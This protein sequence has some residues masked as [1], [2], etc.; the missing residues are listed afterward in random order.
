MEFLSDSVIQLDSFITL[1]LGII[2]LFIGIKITARIRFLQ[3]YNIPEPVTGGIFASL[4]ALALY[5]VGGW[6]VEYDLLD[7]KST[8]LNSSHD[9]ISYAVFCLKKKKQTTKMITGDT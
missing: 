6:E 3:K 7:L 4:A 8:R 5:L 2:V 1:T 9:Q